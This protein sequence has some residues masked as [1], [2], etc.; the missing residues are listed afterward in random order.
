MSREADQEERGSQR[1]G[2]LA[3]GA[4]LGE[5]AAVEAALDRLGQGA[6][7]IEETPERGDALDPDGERK[8]RAEEDD[9][10]RD[11]AGLHRCSEPVKHVKTRYS[12]SDVAR[13]AVGMRSLV[14]AIANAQR[15]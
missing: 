12:R 13:P 8:N 15:I 4:R 2:A 14:T 7:A 10:E 11:T 9:A 5:G 3:G 6:R 1:R